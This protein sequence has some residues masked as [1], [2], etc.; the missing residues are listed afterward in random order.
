M[1]TFEEM[2]FIGQAFLCFKLVG[3]PGEKS[4]LL[5]DLTVSSW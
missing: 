2:E 1:R 4:G 3:Y 5:S